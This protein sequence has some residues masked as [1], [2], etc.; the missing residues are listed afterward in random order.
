MRT[1]IWMKGLA[2]VPVLC[3]VGFSAA[4]RPQAA[5]QQTGDPVADAA[6]KLYR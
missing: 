5:S 4:A 6:R 1:R 2:L 3:L